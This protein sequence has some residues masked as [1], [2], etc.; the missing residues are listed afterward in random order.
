MQN[1]AQW[2]LPKFH[3][4]YKKIRY[5]RLRPRIKPRPKLLEKNNV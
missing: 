3:T 4:K 2:L 1:F 5:F